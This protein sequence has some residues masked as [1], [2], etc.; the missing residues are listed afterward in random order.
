MNPDIIGILAVFQVVLLILFIALMINI[1]NKLGEIAVKDEDW[2]YLAMKKAC[3][4]AIEEF[5]AEDEPN[6][7]IPMEELEVIV[8]QS[9]RKGKKK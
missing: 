3:T 6:P 5:D 7:E 8:E 4:K 9:P 1:N 2:T